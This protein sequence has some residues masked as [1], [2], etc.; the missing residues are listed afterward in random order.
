MASGPPPDPVGETE[1]KGPLLLDLNIA[2]IVLTTTVMATRLYARG[3]VTKALGL[4][5]VIAMVAYCL[6][7]TLSILEITAVGKGAGAPMSTLSPEQLN[8]FFSQLPI[9]QLIFFLACGFVRLSILAFLPRL[10]RDR[11]FMR[12]IWATGVVILTITLAAFFFVLTEC[13]P[14]L[15]VDG[16]DSRVVLSNSPRDLF[17]ATKPNKKC[18]SKQ[19]E[20]YMMWAHAIVG[21]FIDGAL[22]ALPIW[23]IRNKMAAGAKAIKV[24]LVFCVGLFAIMTGIIRL[25]FIVTTDFSVN[26]TYKMY[27]VAP[28]TVLEVHV[29]LWCGCFPSLQPLLRIIS[30]KLGLRSRLESTYKRTTRNTGTGGPSSHNWRASGYVKQQS[31]VDQ[32]QESDGAGR[33]GT[34]SG[35]GDSTTEIMPM[36]SIDHVGRGIRMTTDVI[37]NVEDGV[38]DGRERKTTWD[39]V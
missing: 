22:F 19:K 9:N 34:V 17:H 1:S 23:V 11:I 39:T 37:V 28:W 32:E 15:Y 7:I 16:P 33:R 35:A 29:G 31:T 12:C 8:A 6:A 5:D 18:I 24:I 2:L 13:D 30:F 25:S 4:D 21:I 14:I 38:D 36:G 3:I 20:A 10:S 27:R 26:T